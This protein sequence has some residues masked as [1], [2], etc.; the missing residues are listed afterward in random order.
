MSEADLLSN[1]SAWMGHPAAFLT[2]LRGIP[3][4]S[5]ENVL[6]ACSFVEH[7]LR[8][9]TASNMITMQFFMPAL[10]ASAAI[11]AMYARSHKPFGF[12]R[13]AIWPR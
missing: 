2:D 6:A 7:A 12:T 8:T 13:T 4:T 3:A 10:L 11:P 5:D 1:A 9:R